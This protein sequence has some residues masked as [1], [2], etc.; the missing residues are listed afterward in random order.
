[1]NLWPRSHSQSNGFGLLSMQAVGCTS[2]P[3]QTVLGGGGGG[4]HVEIA[5]IFVG[6][7]VACTEVMLL[8]AVTVMHSVA[9]FKFLF[10]FS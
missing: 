9:C 1:M 6:V 3:Q 10:F 4:E 7:C 5:S 8:G 2:Y